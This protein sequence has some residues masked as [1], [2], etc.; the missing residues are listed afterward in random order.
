MS[1]DKACCF[2]GEGRRR[3]DSTLKDHCE[4]PC[5]S[6]SMSRIATVILPDVPVHVTERGNVWQQVFFEDA[7]YRLYADLL[8]EHASAVGLTLWAN[9]L[10]PS[11]IHSLRFPRARVLSLADTL[12]RTHANF[13]RL[14]NAGINTGDM[15][16]GSLAAS[17][18]S[19]LANGTITPQQLGNLIRKQLCAQ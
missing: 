9:C 5:T 4:S 3:R 14:E 11:H 1:Q 2:E 6:L 19:G 16:L 8:R 15:N 12:G 10:M 18:G 7:D 17:W 13:A